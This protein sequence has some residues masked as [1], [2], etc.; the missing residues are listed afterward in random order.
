MRDVETAQSE[1]MKKQRS[2]EMMI[3]PTERDHQEWNQVGEKLKSSMNSFKMCECVW[4]RSG[5]K[6]RENTQ[7]TYG[8]YK[9]IVISKS[10]IESI[11][12]D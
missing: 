6:E 8:I 5:K 7:T 10:K 9:K 11:K 4:E 1:D 3:L 2:K 12:D